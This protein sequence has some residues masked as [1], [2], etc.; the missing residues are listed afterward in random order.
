[1][2]T[3]D[4]DNH[5]VIVIAVT[6]LTLFTFHTSHIYHGFH[7]ENVLRQNARPSTSP[8]VESSKPLL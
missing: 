1:M 5:D 2:R 3:G 7:R 4:E 6:C 8:T